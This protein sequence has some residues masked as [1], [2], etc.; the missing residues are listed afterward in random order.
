[1]ELLYHNELAK[2]VEHRLS[3]PFKSVKSYELPFHQLA[4][5]E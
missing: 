2:I 5:K 4:L 1:M 3:S